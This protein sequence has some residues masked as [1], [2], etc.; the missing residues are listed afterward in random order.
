MKITPSSPV[1]LPL[2]TGLFKQPA[3]YVHIGEDLQKINVF[4]EY[5]WTYALETSTEK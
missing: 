1:R 2:V 5:L 4:N 3:V